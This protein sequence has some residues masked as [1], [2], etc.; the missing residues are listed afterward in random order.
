M[1]LA[2]NGAL[3]IGTLDGAN[4][5]IK[6]EVGDENIFIFG[7]T[8]EEVHG[9]LKKGYD[10][11]EYYMRTRS[12]APSWTGWDRTTSHR[13][14]TRRPQHA[15]RQSLL[16]R[17]VPLP[18]GL[19]VLKRASEKGGRRL[20]SEV[21]LGE[22]GHSK[23]G[24]N[25]KILKRPHHCG[26]RARHLEDRAGPYLTRRAL[27]DLNPHFSTASRHSFHCKSVIFDES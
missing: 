22:N 3:T 7:H 15:P 8:V 9:F 25:G 19:R 20:P 26:I 23:H 18:G 27:E 6:E 5:E 12:C 17:P 2:L 4:V 11:Q 13:R 14:T 16:Q 24:S 1:K 10:P 21:A